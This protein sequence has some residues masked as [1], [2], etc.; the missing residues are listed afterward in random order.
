MAIMDY[1]L[2]FCDA[3]SIAG[4]VATTVIGNIID[5]GV[6]NKDYG[7]G[8]PIYLHVRMNALAAVTTTSSTI[9]FYLQESSSTTAASFA[10]KLTLKAATGY[11]TYVAGYK[12]YDGAL[13]S[14]TYKR[15]LR[16]ARTVAAATVNSG[17]VDAFIS[18]DPKN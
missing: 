18:L 13:P 15:Y 6:A 4:A 14:A 12:V 8:A 17:S 7:D 5:L 10:N 9:A 16:L 3:T 2:E 11:A 1:R